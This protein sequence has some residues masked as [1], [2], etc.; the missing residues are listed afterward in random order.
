MK[1]SSILAVIAA[2]LLSSTQ[3]V[4]AQD[5]DTEFVTC[6]S[7]IKLSHIEKGTKYYLSSD[8]QRINGRGSSGQQ[9]VTASPES[10]LMS[11]LWIVKEGHGEPP[12]PTGT[13]V[14]LVSKFRLTHLETGANLHSHDRRSPLS[15]QQEVTGYGEHGEGDESDDWMLHP[16]TRTR[17]AY[18]R[19]G[20]DYFM[21]HF[22]THHYLGCTEQAKFTQQNC[23]RGCPVENHLEVFG[24]VKA[25][26]YGF[27]K[28]E[29]GI[30]IHH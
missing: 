6:G 11:S 4:H 7:V 26:T 16:K 23:G 1:S 5:E 15:S 12:C 8:G 10:N 21:S 25:D 13:K 22:E 3:C 2:S 20:E 27:W 14:R 18:W 28:T 30:Y 19:I 29:T 17:D 24:R 9:L